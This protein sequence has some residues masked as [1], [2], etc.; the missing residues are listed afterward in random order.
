MDQSI[1]ELINQ[2]R[3]IRVFITL[4]DHKTQ[5]NM[6]INNYGFFDHSF[7][8]LSQYFEINQGHN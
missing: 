4:H 2:I 5:N 3:P 8:Y 1:I 6:I 7:R